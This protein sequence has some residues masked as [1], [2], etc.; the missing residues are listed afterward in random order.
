MGYDGDAADAGGDDWSDGDAQSYASGDE[1]EGGDWS[2]DDTQSYGGVCSQP[3]P[4]GD[5]TCALG[6]GHLARHA[7]DTTNDHRWWT[8]RPA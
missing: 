4:H 5:G 7:C 3:C 6:I 8:E 1:G 2:G